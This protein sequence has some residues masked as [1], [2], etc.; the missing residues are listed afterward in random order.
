MVGTYTASHRVNV[1]GEPVVRRTAGTNPLTRLWRDVSLRITSPIKAAFRDTEDHREIDM[2]NHRHKFF[3]YIIIIHAQRALNNNNVQ[4]CGDFY[5]V[6]SILMVFSNA[7]KTTAC[8]TLLYSV[9]TV[10]LT[11]ILNRLIDGKLLV[12]H[13]YICRNLLISSKSTIQTN[14][15]SYYSNY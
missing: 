1:Q 14:S 5:A 3:L 8:V 9:T 15:L 2:D 12:I 13:R 6:K 11:Q 4:E 7:V 10:S